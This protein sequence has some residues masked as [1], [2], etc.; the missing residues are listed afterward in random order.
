MK[1]QQHMQLWDVE[2]VVASLSVPLCVFFFLLSPG[3]WDGRQRRI[4]ENYIG[5]FICNEIFPWRLCI[6]DGLQHLGEYSHYWLLFTALCALFA[7]YGNGQIGGILVRWR[8]LY[9]L[10]ASI[11]GSLFERT[12][13]ISP[14]IDL[15]VFSLFFYSSVCRLLFTLAPL[16]VFLYSFLY[17]RCGLAY[18]LFIQQLIHF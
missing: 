7:R 3:V 2:C 18:C 11:D 10:S 17:Y 4:W 13:E 16:F 6:H 9:R 5:D 14:N 15:T 8:P 12:S 1:W